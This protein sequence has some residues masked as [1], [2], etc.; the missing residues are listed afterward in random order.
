MALAFKDLS[1]PSRSTADSLSD[2]V[3]IVILPS[4]DK[5]YLPLCV[6][7]LLRGSHRINARLRL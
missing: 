4:C 6:L 3:R 5:G 7:T 1:L 2:E